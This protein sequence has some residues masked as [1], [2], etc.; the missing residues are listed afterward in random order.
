MTA[1]VLIMGNFVAL[2]SVVPYS[3]GPLAAPERKQNI[4]VQCDDRRDA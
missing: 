3:F 1:A 4:A 2:R